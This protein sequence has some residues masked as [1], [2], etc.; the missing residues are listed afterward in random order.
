MREELT[1]LFVTPEAVPFAKVGGL[2]DVIGALPLTLQQLG[3][4]PLV[5]MPLYGII[6]QG[7][8]SLT[9]AAKDLEVSLG[10]LKL[11][12]DLYTATSGEVPFYFVERDEFYERRQIYGTPRGDYFDNLERYTFLAQSILPICRALNLKPD[13]LHCHDWQAALVPIYLKTRWA[14][15]DH[16]MNSASV[17]TIHNLGY[18]GKFPKDKFPLLGLDWS[19]FSINGLEYY[20]DINFLKGGIIFADTVTTVSRRYSREIQTPEYGCGLEGVLQSRADVLTGIVNGVDYRAWNPATDPHLAANYD[21]RK[22]AGKAKNKKA[23]MKRFGL[24]PA[25]GQAPLLGMISR[26]TDQK[27]FNLLAEVLPELMAADLSLVILG[28]GD[29]KYQKLLT[30]AAQQYQGRLGV[31]IAYDNPLAHLI[32]AGADM[33]LMPS[34]YE[35]CGLNQIYS[36]KYGTIP[37]VRATGGLVDTVEPVDLQRATGTG[38]MFEEYK[39][40]AFLTAIRE[41]YRAYQ[42]KTLWRKLMKNAMAQDFSWESSAKAYIELYQQT[43]ARH[44]SELR[45]VL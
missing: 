22:L 45:R 12:F 9:L 10:P 23:L 29:E 8:H 13:I 2:A 39:A 17:L 43:I 42:N 3:L 20:G 40:P 1:V 32:E 21:S 16:F 44:K 25:L 35:P 6:K 19:L 37:V 24:D 14:G 30:E 5:V 33:F 11:E 15:F 28:S 34:Y 7:G 38:F 31:A 27:G 41:A 4:K 26:L 36:M 18:Q